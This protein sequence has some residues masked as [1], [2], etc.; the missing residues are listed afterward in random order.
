[1]RPASHIL[2]ALGFDYAHLLSCHLVTYV[3]ASTQSAASSLPEPQ[4]HRCVYELAWWLS[5]KSEKD[6]LFVPLNTYNALCRVVASVL[7]KVIAILCILAALLLTFA[8]GVI[9]IAHI[10]FPVALFNAGATVILLGAIGVAGCIGYCSARLVNGPARRERLAGAE[11][12]RGFDVRLTESYAASDKTWVLEQISK[13][14]AKEGQ[15]AEAALDAFNTHM[16][17]K[18]AQRVDQLQ[19]SREQVIRFIVLTICGFFVV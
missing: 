2:H 6:I 17:T 5:Q 11:Q 3:C 10:S 4:L 8:L 1:M 15:S 7:P 13:W 18:V 19:Q 14:Y 16:R 9:R 12:L